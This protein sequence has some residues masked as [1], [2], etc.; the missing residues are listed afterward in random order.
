MLYLRQIGGTRVGRKKLYLLAE[1]DGETEQKLAAYYNLLF[2]HGL[3]GS[4]TKGIPY[5]FTLGSTE[6]K[7]EGNALARL[8]ALCP[9]M[10]KI[11]ICFAHLGLFGQKV[12]F[13]APNMNTQLLSLQACFFPECGSGAHPWSAHATLLIDNPAE[14]LKAISLVSG[15]FHPFNGRI[16]HLS[17]YEFF[18]ARLIARIELGAPAG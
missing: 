15:Q 7:E 5:H 9:H 13:V 17:L 18:P 10:G 14:I 1:F 16:T 12:L 6:G 11:D 4:Q 2:E 3:R 8:L